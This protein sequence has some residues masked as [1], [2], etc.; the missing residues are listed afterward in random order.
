VKILATSREKLNVQSETN[1]IIGGLDVPGLTDTSA[2][3]AFD[4]I[5]LFIQSAGKTRPGFSPSPSELLLITKICRNVV[6]MPLAIELAAAWLHV[7]TVGEIAS[8]LEKGFDLLE[9][10]KRDAP[11]RHSS[12]R[13]VFNQSWLLLDQIEQELFTKLSVFRG[14]FTREAAEHVAGAT[15]HHLAGLVNKSFLSYDPS[16]GRFELHE[17]LRQYAQEHLEES[18]EVRLEVQEAYAAYF[19]DFME[20]RG[21]DLRGNKQKIVIH[22]IMADFENVRAAWRYYLEQCDA[23]KLWKVITGLWHVYWI[24]W[25]NL[26]GMEIF[27]EA[28]NALNDVVD[29]DCLALRGLAMAFQSYFMGWV[30]LPETGYDLAQESVEILSQFNQLEALVFAYDSLA[31]NAYFLGRMSEEREAID[32]MLEVSKELDDQWL[33]AFTLFAAGMVTLI[34]GDYA[35]ARRLAKTTLN[36][37]KELGD[38]SAS[39]TPY[40]IL[41]HAALA[42]GEYDDAREHYLRCLAMAE[43]ANFYYSIQTASKYLGKLLTSTRNLEEAEFYLYKSLLITREIG[44][45][46]DIINLI[47]EFARLRV[48]QGKMEHAVE[49]LAMVIHHPSSDHIRW[50]EGSIRESAE[51]LLAKLEDD[52]SP[53]LLNAAVERGRVSNLD[54]VVAALL[55]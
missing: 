12:I 47:Y 34:E 54:V 1:Y 35:E 30:G 25:R 27:A 3:D 48:E 29:D 38:V 11:E 33:R 49:M 43:D 22:E 19:A 24:R 42:L 4:A 10:D 44:W 17:L 13:E 20:T 53:E 15:L 14:G 40:I 8:E 32:M 18:Q 5:S 46:R 55:M 51:N 50:L 9:T 21:V 41:G 6:G 39:S 45:V 37:Y 2:I 16:E 31:L 28:V 7:L 23:P 36:I 52:L 26:A